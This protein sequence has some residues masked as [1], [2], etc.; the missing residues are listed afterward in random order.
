[1]APLTSTMYKNEMSD[2]ASEKDTESVETKEVQD[3]TPK[4]QAREGPKIVLDA[5]KQHL[6]VRQHLWQ[7]WCVYTQG[8]FRCMSSYTIQ[9]T[10]GPAA[11]TAHIFRGYTGT[12]V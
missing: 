2:K 11:T 6:R 12:S 4:I 9:V 8:L 5:G 7:I 10:E 1:M 3:A